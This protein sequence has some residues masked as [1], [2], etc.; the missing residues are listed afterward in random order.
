MVGAALE[1]GVAMVRREPPDVE[2]A[3][4]FATQVFLGGIERVGAAD[5]AGQPPGLRA[6]ATSASEANASPPPTPP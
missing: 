6:S 3:T 4:R 1:V 2:G 5:A